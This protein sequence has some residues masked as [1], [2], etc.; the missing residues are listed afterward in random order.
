MDW[1]VVVSAGGEPGGLDDCFGVISPCSGGIFASRRWNA[2]FWLGYRDFFSL[3]AVGIINVLQSRFLPLL[4]VLY[5][6][7]WD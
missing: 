2:S 4:R 1:G 3:L 5:L 7:L 6:V